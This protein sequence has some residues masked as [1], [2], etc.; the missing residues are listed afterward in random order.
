MRQQTGDWIFGCAFVG[1]IVFC[2][3]VVGTFIYVVEHFI[4]KAW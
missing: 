4:A 1:T 3:M 2:L